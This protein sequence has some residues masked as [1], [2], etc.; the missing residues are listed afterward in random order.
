MDKRTKTKF[1]KMLAEYEWSFKDGSIIDSEKDPVKLKLVSKAYGIPE[2]S[3]GIIMNDY[4]DE[5]KPK[6]VVDDVYDESCIMDEVNRIMDYNGFI[7]NIRTMSYSRETEKLDRK[8]GKKVMKEIPYTE[9]INAIETAITAAKSNNGGKYFFDSKGLLTVMNKNATTIVYKKLN[10]IMNEMTYTPNE[11]FQKEW[12]MR[13]YQE[14]RIEQDFDI[15]EMMMKHFCWQIKRKMIEYPT[16]NDILL[17]FHGQ[18]GIGKSHLFNKIFENALSDFHTPGA[19]LQSICDPNQSLALNSQYCMNIE[20]MATGG[21]LDTQNKLSDKDIAV[22]K[23]NLTGTHTNMR[24]FFTQNMVSLRI[25]ASFLS[26]TNKH[27]YEIINDDTGMRRFMEF[28]SSRRTQEVMNYAEVDWIAS[29]SFEFFKTVDEFNDVGY[30]ILNSPTGEKIK[31]IQKTYITSSVIRYLNTLT[32]SD[33]KDTDSKSHK[34]YSLTEIYEKYQ[35]F[36][37]NN[38]V[39]EKFRTSRKNFKSKFE[40]VYGQGAIRSHANCDYVYLIEK[41]TDVKP[42]TTPQISEFN[43]PT[44]NKSTAE[45][46]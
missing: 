9:V 13:L 44:K 40:D 5:L 32:I 14:Y 1:E 25:R 34:K 24:V 20:E 10:L 15:F 29:N 19:T 12:L 45:L 22:L 33:N 16:Q 35:D 42:T 2:G 41:P 17:S 37:V 6:A 46:T 23:K 28:T 3:M 18:Q 36:C 31:N 27:L 11:S 7:L 4:A 8:T 21:G 43:I 38:Y 26:C 39:E 30:L